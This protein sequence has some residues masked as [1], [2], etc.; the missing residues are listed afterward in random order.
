MFTKFFCRRIIAAD[1]SPKWLSLIVF[2]ILVISLPGHAGTNTADQSANKNTNEQKTVA[3]IIETVTMAW[4]KNE[5]DTIAGL[6]LPD[7]I[8]VMPT[9]S[10][11]KSRS[12]I[13]KRL[14]D[15]RNGKLKDTTLENRIAGITF[16]DNQAA[17]VRGDY[18]L[19][20]MKILG[21][22]TSPAG[23]FVFHQKK[24]QGRW[25]IAKAEILR[26]AEES[27]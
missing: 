15:E 3:K 13:R 17:I 16:R 7:A 19:H 4:N 22:E 12:A 9:G 10:V 27:N 20:G 6:F 26:R 8:L 11:V 14:I 18:Q 21:I 24:H 25:M 2:S 1:Y 23:K 5:P